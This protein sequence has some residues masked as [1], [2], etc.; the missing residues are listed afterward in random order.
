[1]RVKRNY[2]PVNKSSI[3][4]ITNRSW[5]TFISPST[6]S[7]TTVKNQWTNRRAICKITIRNKPTKLQQYHLD[8]HIIFSCSIQPH[9]ER[10]IVDMK[11]DHNIRDMLWYIVVDQ[12]CHR[13]W[14]PSQ[15]S[16][17]CHSLPP[18]W[19]LP[20]KRSVH[21]T[22]SGRPL[23]FCSAS[24]NIHQ[25]LLHCPSS[26]KHKCMES[27]SIWSTVLIRLSSRFG[28]RWIWCRM[29]SFMS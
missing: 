4:C 1:M 27:S 21:W 13:P 12:I 15:I 8:R 17:V 22:S 9:V 10:K 5:P 26:G 18:I 2:V 3:P 23:C 16:L 7:W 14:C 11:E 28:E 19:L 24:F 20:K 25:V 29:V 6:T